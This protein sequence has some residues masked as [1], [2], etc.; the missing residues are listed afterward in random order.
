MTLDLLSHPETLSVGD[1]Q[2]LA[3]MG[4]EINVTLTQKTS[5]QL[6][7]NRR[8]SRRTM[9]ADRL[10]VLSGFQMSHRNSPILHAQKYR[11][12]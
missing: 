9:W 4:A 6:H 5:E 7:P 2:D 1:P 3:A 10:N 11:T 8:Q 12:I